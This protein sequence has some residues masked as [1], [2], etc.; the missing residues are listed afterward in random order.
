MV[1]HSLLINAIDGTYL[2]HGDREVLEQAVQSWLDFLEFPEGTGEKVLTIHGIANDYTR[3]DTTTV[4]L[5]EGIR[6][7]E[8]YRCPLG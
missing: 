5:A 4:V 2:V 6:G 7:M 1:L 3:A 8:I